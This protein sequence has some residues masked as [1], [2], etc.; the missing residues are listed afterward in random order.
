MS[1]VL[2][3]G[4]RYLIVY[5]SIHGIQRNNDFYVIFYL[6]VQRIL[7]SV[8]RILYSFTFNIIDL[9]FSVRSI[10]LLRRTTSK[11]LKHARY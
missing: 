4:L 2:F 7:L 9:S 10:G 5:V 6:L 3:G 11:K 8:T 1:F